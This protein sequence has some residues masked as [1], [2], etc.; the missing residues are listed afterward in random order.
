MQAADEASMAGDFSGGSFKHGGELT[1]FFRRDG[2]FLVNT[3][4]PDGRAADFE[5]K[6]A[7]GLEPLQQYLIELPGGRLQALGVA[8]DARKQAQGGQR[9]YH[10][11]PAQ[12][13]KP[14]A[15]LHWTGL[16]QTWNYQCADCHSTNLRKGYDEKTASYATRWSEMNVSCEACHGP[17]SNHV[18]W[19]QKKPGWESLSTSKGLTAQLDERKGAGWTIAAESGNAVRARPRDSAREIEVC[20]RCHARRGQFSDD[21]AAGQPFHDAFRP[22]LLDPGLYHADG[23]QRDEVYTYG[24]FLQSKMHAAGVTCSD[25]H[26]P[27]G[28]KPRTQGNALCAQCHAPARYDGAAHHHH[29]PDSKGAACTACHMPTTTYMGVDPRHDH[30]FRVPRPDRSTS[31]GT[32]N[33]CNACHARQDAKWAAAKIRDWYPA[34]KPGFQYFAEA[35]HAAE[36]GA[37]NAQS[38]LGELVRNRENPAFVRAS[39][40][41]RLNA[42]PSPYSLDLAVSALNDADPNVRVAA[43]GVLAGMD[44]ATRLKF[45]PPRLEDASRVA[46]MDAARALAGE[47]ERRLSAEQHTA[48][49][50]ALVE[51]LAAQQFNA[52][53]P[54]AQS[55]LGGLYLAQ[56]RFDAAEAALKQALA[57]DPAFS[58]ATANLADLYRA[59]GRDDEAEKTL[60][61]GLQKAP[62]AAAL[63]H[64]LG[65]AL[66]RQGRMPEAL[67]ELA[68]AVRLEPATSR[69]A[70]VLAVAQHDGG[71]P[72]QARATL[73][74]ALKRLPY[75]RDLL[76]AS[77]AYEREAGQAATR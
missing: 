11:Y 60:R 24:S 32:P 56:G 20:A 27:H 52:D 38:G 73:S 50:R 43:V 13:L 48:F 15:A 39:A 65:L 1:R 6:Y 30:S 29:Q 63:H 74:A 7:F 72:E 5:I 69:Y 23:Q 64:A 12:N 35:F 49:E 16:D 53:R 26:E 45:L 57:L 68:R 3:P 18:V 55:N 62:E 40:L 8:W 47:P 58:P 66:V 28:G 36:Q 2:K 46:R 14:G 76:A 51:Y 9:W 77:A 42:F 34:P 37:P 54:E 22:A 61:A 4:G 41:S 31:L 67:A 71:Q 44:A 25:C 33:A 59:M 17:A 70:Y 19:A 75:D 21:F 10:L